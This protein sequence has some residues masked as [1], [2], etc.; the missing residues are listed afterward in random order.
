GYQPMK[1]V[2]ILHGPFVGVFR[3]H[4]WDLRWKSTLEVRAFFFAIAQ[5]YRIRG[6]DELRWRR[7]RASLNAH[8]NSEWRIGFLRSFVSVIYRSALFQSPLL[9]RHEYRA[10]IGTAVRELPMALF[11]YWE[12]LFDDLARPFPHPSRSIGVGLRW[13]ADK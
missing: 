5:D 13:Y 12:Q 2:I 7:L 10:E 11:A 1:R 3:Q 8:L 9:V 4:R 6:T